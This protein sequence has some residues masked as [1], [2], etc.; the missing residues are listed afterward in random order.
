[1]KQITPDEYCEG[2]E[3]IYVEQ[4]K[5]KTGGDGISAVP[6]HSVFMLTA[7]GR[8]IKSACYHHEVVSA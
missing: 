3:S 2:V 5:Y 1:M 4:P 6:I 8:L 7:D